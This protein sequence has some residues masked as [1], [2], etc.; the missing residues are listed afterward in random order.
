MNRI[1]I[2]TAPP[3]TYNDDRRR[4]CI[5]LIKLL[6]RYRRKVWKQIVRLP[7]IVLLAE[8]LF[9]VFPGSSDIIYCAFVLLFLFLQLGL[10][11]PSKRVLCKKIYELTTNIDQNINQFRGKLPLKMFML[12]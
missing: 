2:L 12:I 3:R 11:F 7:G 5:F 9:V 6:G 4:Y 1:G 8:V 10:S